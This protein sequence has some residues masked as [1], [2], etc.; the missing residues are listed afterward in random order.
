MNPATNPA[1]PEQGE[2][3]T[4]QNPL[5]TRHVMF[6]TRPDIIADRVFMPRLAISPFRN[7]LVVAFV[8]AMA[9]VCPVF[10]QPA[11]SHAAADLGRAVLAASL[12][13]SA[14]YHVRDLEISQEDAQ[15]YL[16]DGYLIFGKPVNGAPIAAVFSADVDG[17]DAEV[18]LLPPNRSERKALSRYTNSPNLDEHFTNAIFLFTEPQARAL[19]EQIRAK[20]EARQAPEVGA[21]LAEQWSAAVGNLTG[22]FETRFVLD[23]LNHSSAQHGFF[24]A[25]IQGKKLGNFDVGFDSHGDEQLNAGQI[26]TRDG[27]TYWDTWTSFVARSR[28]NLAPPTPEEEIRSYRMEATLDANFTLHCITRIRIKTTADSRYAIPFDLSG[29]MRTTEA[30]LDGVPAEIFLR[31]SVR[32]GFAQANG[33][34]LLIV[35]PPQP[36][37]PGTE[38]EIEIHHEGNVVLDAGHQVYFVTSRGTWY[39]GR[40]TQ[41]ARYDVT[42]RYPKTLNLISAGQVTED[43]TEG[44]LRITRRVTDGRLDMLA[45]NLG[46]YDAKTVEHNGLQIEVNANHEVE[47]ALRVRQPDPLPLSAGNQLLPRRGLRGVPELGGERP[48]LPAAAPLVDR[49]AQ[50]SQVANQ[51]AAAVDFFRTRFGEPPLTRI[52]VSPLPG[53]FGQGFAGMIYLPT[54]S[55]LPTNVRPLS[56]MPAWQQVFYSGLMLVHEAAHQ[57]WGNIVTASGYHH[58]WLTE[59]V[60]NY[61]ALLFLESQHGTKFIDRILDEYR[62]ELL[63]KGADGEIIESVGPVVQGRRLDSSTNPAAWNTIAYGKGTWIIHMLRQQ[64]GDAAFTKMLTELRRRYE[65]KTI[66]TEQFRLLCAEFVPKGSSDP[67]LEIFFDQWVYGTGMP[68][69]KLTYS[70]KGKPGAWKLTGTLAQSEVPEDFSVTVPI[71]IQTGKGKVVRQIRTSSEPVQFSVPVTIANAKAVLDPGSSVLR[72]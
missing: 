64:L 60:S 57:W 37:E 7:S 52:E 63:A 49:D 30:S 26:N 40:G 42:W 16:T 19:A 25:I 69:L 45:F 62:R 35:V 13:R 50:L 34:E 22:S 15:F 14:C 6:W 5:P 4:R 2:I 54:L 70:V 68:A 32:D 21:V 29:Q 58:E 11:Q 3:P 51:I 31:E 1:E 67:K 71:E 43:R 56:L 12:D 33:N 8:Q 39:P 38:H 27:K 53:R 41:F 61:S 47:D 72:R 10:A 59:A 65:W 9:L 18:L 20:G 36:L 28:R 66:D 24:D 55:Y 17:G 44:D 48:E 46:Q 23:L